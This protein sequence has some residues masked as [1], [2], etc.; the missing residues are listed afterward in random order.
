[1]PNFPGVIMSRL[2]QKRSTVDGGRMVKR[3]R[4]GVTRGYVQ[5]PHNTNMRGLGRRIDTTKL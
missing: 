4:V 2:G 1:M 5:K 3:D